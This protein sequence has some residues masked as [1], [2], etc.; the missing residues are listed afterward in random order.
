MRF[1]SNFTRE[2]KI[3]HRFLVRDHGT[4]AM[5]PLPCFRNTDWDFINSTKLALH[6]NLT[7]DLSQKM[8]SSD[9]LQNQ[10]FAPHEPD[11]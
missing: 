9:R 8:Q 11:V 6:W 10:N 3:H 5:A 1:V 4:T 7:W 2:Q